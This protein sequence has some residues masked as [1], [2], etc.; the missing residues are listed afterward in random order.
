M[1]IVIREREGRRFYEV[2][3]PLRHASNGELYALRHQF[4]ARTGFEKITL[5]FISACDPKSRQPQFSQDIYFEKIPT[6]WRVRGVTIDEKDNTTL[7][8][9]KY[10]VPRAEY[11]LTTY[12]QLLQ[13]Q[14]K[15]LTKSLTPPPKTS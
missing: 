2:V 7:I 5:R 15:K 13:Q 9:N 12:L 8:P 14:P 4:E 3:Y 6:G 10:V 11:L 1:E